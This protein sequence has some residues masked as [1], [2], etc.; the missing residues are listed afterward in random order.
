MK[1][2]MMLSVG[3]ALL[4]ALVGCSSD[5]T[6]ATTNA[7]TSSTTASSSSGG[8]CK[9]PEEALYDIPACD[10]CQQTK[11]CDKIVACFADKDCTTLYECTNACYSSDAGVAQMNTCADACSSAPTATDAANKLYGDQ[12]DCVTTGCTACK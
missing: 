9:I 11:C 3:T 7:T 6:P 8:A 12:D 5:T 2:F 10:T 1:N 4:T